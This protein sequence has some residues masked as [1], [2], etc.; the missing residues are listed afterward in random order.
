[1]SRNLLFVHVRCWIWSSFCQKMW[2]KWRVAWLAYL[3]HAFVTHGTTYNIKAHPVAY[4]GPTKRRKSAR[5]AFWNEMYTTWWLSVWW[6]RK[7]TKAS[8]MLWE[9]ISVFRFSRRVPT[10]GS[11]VKKVV[12]HSYTFITQVSTFVQLLYNRLHVA[13]VNNEVQPNLLRVMVRLYSFQR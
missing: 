2:S 8:I 9:N 3:I 13:T 10:R 11:V 4:L 12:V 1:M 5:S 6:Q 7:L